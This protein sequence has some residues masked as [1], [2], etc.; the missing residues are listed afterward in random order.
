VGTR[1]TKA[2]TRKARELTEWLDG[3]RINPRFPSPLSKAGPSSDER[4]REEN[5]PRR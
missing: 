2:L 4:S 5:L 1:A 3:T